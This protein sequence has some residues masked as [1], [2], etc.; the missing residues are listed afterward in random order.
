MKT[1]RLLMAVAFLFSLNVATAQKKD[2]KSK[3]DK[4]EKKR[5]KKMTRPKKSLL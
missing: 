3:S 5:I 4:T 2:D 1:L